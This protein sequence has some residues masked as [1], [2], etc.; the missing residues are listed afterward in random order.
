MESAKHLAG[1]YPV[2]KKLYNLF[3]LDAIQRLGLPFLEFGYLTAADLD[4]V[5]QLV[6]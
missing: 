1:I 3:T 4:T 6:R 2:L 5:K